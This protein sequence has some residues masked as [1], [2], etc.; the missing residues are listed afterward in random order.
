MNQAR[1]RAWAQAGVGGTVSRKVMGANVDAC[2]S[3][4]ALS[5][6]SGLGRKVLAFPPFYRWEN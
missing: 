3:V 2:S 5:K 6:Y 1:R 4:P